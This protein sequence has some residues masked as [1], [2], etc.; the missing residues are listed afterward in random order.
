M[1]TMTS[2]ALTP[3][4][5]ASE[6]IVGCPVHWF[7]PS[8]R[9]ITKL[10]SRDTRAQRYGAARATGQRLARVVGCGPRWRR[11]AGRDRQSGLGF[12]FLG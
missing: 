9:L 11:C 2:E 5:A 12:E 6:A 4:S 8:D 3:S 10:R 1:V 7:C